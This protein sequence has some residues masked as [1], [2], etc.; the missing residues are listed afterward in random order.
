ML[1][2]TP[3]QSRGEQGGIGCARDHVAG[4]CTALLP[5]RCCRHRGAL[6]LHPRQYHPSPNPTTSTARVTRS[7]A[8]RGIKTPSREP[9]TPTQA[10]CSGRRA[11]VRAMAATS[12]GTGSWR[13]PRR[14]THDR[15]TMGNPRTCRT[16]DRSSASGRMLLCGRGGPRAR[17][18]D[19]RN[20]LAL[21]PRSTGSLPRPR[22]VTG[23]GA[24]GARWSLPVDV[25]WTHT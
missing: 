17:R 21:Q 19:P 10:G 25:D 4:F 11:P 7:I 16:L 24:G 15:A 18:L 1:L 9:R 8:R 22:R 13:R 20:V 6:S 14:R 3:L 5:A 12:K 23:S 2:V